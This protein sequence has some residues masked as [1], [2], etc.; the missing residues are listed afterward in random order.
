[1]LGD[2]KTAIGLAREYSDALWKAAK[3]MSKIEKRFKRGEKISEQEMND[4][5]TEYKNILALTDALSASNPTNRAVKTLQSKISKI[6][7][8]LDKD[9]NNADEFKLKEGYYEYL[10]AG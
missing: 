9:L 5:I 8:T 1:M 2:M 4:L 3:K 7:T 10:K 6:I